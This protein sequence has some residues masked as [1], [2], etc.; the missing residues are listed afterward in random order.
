VCEGG[1]LLPAVS[2]L[3]LQQTVVHVH[4]VRQVQPALLISWGPC[5]FGRVMRSRV[6]IQQ[7]T[8]SLTPG[9]RYTANLQYYEVYKNS[10]IKANITT[11]IELILL[12]T[13]TAQ[14]FPSGSIRFYLILSYLT[15]TITTTTTTTTNNNNNNNNTHNNHHN[16]NYH[17]VIIMIIPV[18]SSGGRYTCD[19]GSAD[20][21]CE[22]E[23]ESCGAP[24]VGMQEIPRPLTQLMKQPGVRLVH[25]AILGQLGGRRRD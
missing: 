21:V 17:I 23:E 16:Y 14:E 15:M 3:R 1:R 4:G 6:T 7:N 2:R 18:K 20:Q 12:L 8:V 13:S 19:C 9:C 24:E 25:H 5:T 22:G 11:I 10:A